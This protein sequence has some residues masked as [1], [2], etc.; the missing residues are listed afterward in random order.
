M[1]DSYQEIEITGLNSAQAK[2]VMDV[3]SAIAGF[4]V[5]VQTHSPATNILRIGV[6]GADLTSFLSDFRSQIL[7][8]LGRLPDVDVSRANT[9]AMS[10][11]VR[12]KTGKDRRAER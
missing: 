6:G 2:G 3:V 4:D 1:S 8:R 10:P 11:G 9:N 7:S 12:C 5:L